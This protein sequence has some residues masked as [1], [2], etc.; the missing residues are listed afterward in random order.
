MLGKRLL[1][2]AIGIPFAIYV[3]NYGG[4]LFYFVAN[5]LALAGI[6]ELLAMFR[7]RGFTPSFA[8]SFISGLLMLAVANFGNFDEMSFLITALIISS[9][10]MLI[11]RKNS[12]PVP[13]AAITILSTLYV[14]WL[15]AFLILLRNIST[16][17]ITTPLGQIS[18]GAAFTWMA[19][20]ATWANDTSAFFIGSAIGKHKLCPEISPGK[21]VEGAIGGLAGSL[22]VSVFLGMLTHIPLIHTVILGLLMG[23]LGPVGDLVESSFK[24]YAEVKDSGNIFPGHG[25]VLDRFDSL[26]F[27]IPVVY[28]YLKFFIIN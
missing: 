28:Y 6:W 17:I 27:V 23:V 14:G 7:R 13:D 12:L 10:C 3:V 26:L 22:I 9:L 18:A 20:I 11:L 16:D 2:A 24:R 8:I 25:G 19:L 5:L 15:F 21:T 4:L 1:T